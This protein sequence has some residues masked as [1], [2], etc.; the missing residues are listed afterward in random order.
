MI[1]RRAEKHPFIDCLQ[2]G[3]VGNLLSYQTP[4]SNT[5]RFKVYGLRDRLAH[6]VIPAGDTTS[7]AL[8]RDK[9]DKGTGRNYP[10]RNLP[11]G[12]KS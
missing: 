12:E 5:A 4:Q 6:L 1:L 8:R 11:V 9:G 3:I 2:N 10:Q 7:G